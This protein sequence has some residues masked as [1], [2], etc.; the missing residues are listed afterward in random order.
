MFGN[1]LGASPGFGRLRQ[2][3][4]LSA[5]C[6]LSR[7]PPLSILA[8]SDVIGHVPHV[9]DVLHHEGSDSGVVQAP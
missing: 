8:Q 4:V 2:H 7:V 9:G 5:F 1:L 6:A 3:L